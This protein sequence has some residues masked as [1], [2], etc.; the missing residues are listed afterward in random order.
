MNKLAISASTLLLS[1]FALTATS[2]GGSTS[3]DPAAGAPAQAATAD[4]ATSSALNIRYIDSDSLMAHYNLAKD[5]QE[6]SMRAVSK[7]ESA[8]QA[9]AGEIQKFAA[10]IEQK[11]RSN[12]YLSEASYNAD[13]QKLQKMQQ[14][15]EN[16][17]ANLSRNTENELGQQQL[18]L[19]DSFENFVQVYNVSKGYDAILFKAAGIYFNPSLDIT[20]DIIDGLNARYNKVDSSK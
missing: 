8:R 19:N 16:Y 11:A 7:I 3:S 15:A 13:M 17:L 20:R 6:A 12:G 10:A 14:D 9:K 1:L 18:Q 5:F 2:C 4:G